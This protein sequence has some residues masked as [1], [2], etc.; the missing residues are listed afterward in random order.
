MRQQ[1]L[2]NRVGW[3]GG[4]LAKMAKNCMK[5]TKLTFLGQTV[6]G[7]GGS[8]CLVSGAGDPTLGE[9]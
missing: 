7:H 9:T 6:R 3:W 4:N 5:I 2:P 8:N 1:G